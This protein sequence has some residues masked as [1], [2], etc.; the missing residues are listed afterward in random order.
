MGEIT[1][2][3]RDILAD[4]EAFTCNKNARDQSSTHAS[5]IR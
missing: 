2:Q 3:F 4:R 5:K 1:T